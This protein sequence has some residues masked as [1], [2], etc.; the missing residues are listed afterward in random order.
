MKSIIFWGHSIVFHFFEF[1]ANKIDFRCK[2]NF[3]WKDNIQIHNNGIS[4]LSFKKLSKMCDGSLEKMVDGA[5][6]DMIVIQFGGND[7][8]KFKYRPAKLA[9]K[10]I[11]LAKSLKRICKAQTV[12]ICKILPR[13]E[14]NRSFSFSYLQ[15]IEY[16]SWARTVNKNLKN[17]ASDNMIF[18]NHQRN[19]GSKKA[20]CFRNDGVHL[21]QYGQF[22]LYKS[23]R[24]AIIFALKCLV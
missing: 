4:G 6:Y 14:G 3:N 19:F 20:S 23:W 11:K 1:L 8:K 5:V 13:F 9:K 16:R 2:S 17:F 15:A 18:W 21:N 24:G 22:L 7:Y 12:V 10:I